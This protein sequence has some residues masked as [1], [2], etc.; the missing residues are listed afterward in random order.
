MPKSVYLIYEVEKR[1]FLSRIFLAAEILKEPS[2]KYEV[3]ILQHNQISLIALFGKPGIIVFKSCPDQYLGIMKL[4]K[5]RGFTI[6]LLQEEGIH[7]NKKLTDQ[8]EFSY[9]CAELVDWYMAWHLEDSLFAQKM[10]IPE[11]KVKILGNIRF[12]L[13]AKQKVISKQRIDDRLRILILENFSMGKFYTKYNPNSNFLMDSSSRA[14]L[15]HHLNAM[16]KAAE[17]NYML[18]LNLY[19]ELSKKNYDIKVR[20]YSIDNSTNAIKNFK[21]DLSENILEALSECD[22]VIHY[23]STAGLEAILAGR[24]SLILADKSAKVYD[25]RLGN[26]SEEFNQVDKLVRYLDQISIKDISSINS[27]QAKL[28]TFEYGI[29]YSKQ[30]TSMLILKLLNNIENRFIFYRQFN[31]DTIKVLIRLLWYKLVYLLKKIFLKSNENLI[32]SRRINLV[33]FKSCLEFLNLDN[34]AKYVK[35]SPNG[36]RLYLKN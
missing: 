29:D 16:T 33:K 30:V 11:S 25:K 15:T 9:R 13:A 32:K 27:V 5:K 10:K 24:I 4:M 14:N 23:G 19:S 20:R 34:P 17:L 18:Y 12:Q 7:Y 3:I 22:I 28:V 35:I 26:C 31:L 21:I 1:E 8:F 36:K 6:L 2:I